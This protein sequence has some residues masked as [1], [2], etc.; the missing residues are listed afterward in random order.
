MTLGQ[1]VVVTKALVVAVGLAAILLVYRLAKRRVAE[2][3][4]TGGTSTRQTSLKR[5]PVPTGN[6][7]R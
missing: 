5:C 1:K 7:L 4:C 2:L 3:N 6:T